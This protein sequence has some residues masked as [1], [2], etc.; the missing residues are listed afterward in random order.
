MNPHTYS[1]VEAAEIVGRST[2][3]LR[4]AID[5]EDLLAARQ[6][7][8]AI[9]ISRAELAKWWRLR[10]GGDLFGDSASGDLLAAIREIVRE[11]IAKGE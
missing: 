6:S 11:E 4:R 7:S 9:R 1:L 3:T 10:G 5:A 2:R 8:G